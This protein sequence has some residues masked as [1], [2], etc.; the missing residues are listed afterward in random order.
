MF[1]DNFY[2]SPKKVQELLLDGIKLS[3]QKVLEPSA[4]KGDLAEAIA[5]NMYGSKRVFPKIDVVESENEL[6]SILQGKGFN[7]VGYDF[8]EYQTN[9]EYQAIIMNPPFDNGDKHVLHAIKLAENQVSNSCY[10]SA[11]VNAE[12]IRNPYSVYR[13]E[14]LQLLNNYNAEITYHSDLFKGEGVE[15]KTGVETAIIKLTVN[16]IQRR[17]STSYSDIINNVN[18]SNESNTLENSLSTIVHSNEVQARVNDIKTLVKQYQ[19]HIKLLKERYMADGAIAYLERL[20]DGFSSELSRLPEINEDI[21]RLRR[22]YW[23]AI[24]KTDEFSQNLTGHGR[25]QLQKQLDGA[26]GLEITYSNIEMLLMAVA[27]NSSN[28][29]MDSCLNM[30]ER[31]TQYHNNEFSTNIHYFNGWNSN[32]AFKINPKFIM[33]LTDRFSSGF[34][35]EDM[36]AGYKYLNYDR[37]DFIEYQKVTWSVREFIT[38]LIKMLKLIDASVT[39][40][41]RLI[42]LGEYETDK[43]R[44][45]MFKKGTVHFWFKDL[46]LLEKFNVMCGQQYN[47]LPTDEEIKQHETAR[48]FMKEQKFD[49]YLKVKQL[50]A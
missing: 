13:K 34:S 18:S 37:V 20:V 46:D 49:R 15:R 44:F 16:P 26:K 4:G 43:I 10:I 11:I 28:I 47:W 1:N 30:F 9:T 38:D 36:G 12:T 19:Y 41:F 6:C 40:D 24:L 31:I 50:G 3:T 22:Q 7:L 14:L 23:T 42:K 8:L 33:P 25:E 32:S 48:K 2:P 29:L 5:D 21:E 45:K 35:S 39:D 17:V 27:Q